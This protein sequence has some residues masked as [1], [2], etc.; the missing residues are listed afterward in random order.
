MT[1]IEKPSPPAPEASLGRDPLVKGS[2]AAAPQWHIV[3]AGAALAAALVWGAISAAGAQLG[4]L[5]VVGLL[6][7]VVLYRARFGFTSAWRQLV[8]VGQGRA[9]RA[10]MVMLAAGS[11]LFALVL[12]Q[13]WGLFGTTP[14]PY[15]FPLGVSL[16]V[17]SFLFGLGMQLAGSCASGTLYV[18]GSGQGVTIVTLI[19]FIAGS[20]LGSWSFPFWTK[21]T[22]AGP[23]VSLARSRLGY[24]GALLIQLAA[25]ALIAGITLYIQRRRTPPPIEESPTIPGWSRLYRG[26]WP[27]I[28]GALGLAAL[29]A[30]TL[31]LSGQPW[32][33]TFA[34]ALWG[35]KAL[36]GIGY[37]ISQWPY[38]H[39]GPNA[40]ALHHS[41]LANV[42]STMDLGIILGA[43]I[44]AGLAGSF[45]RWRLPR[46]KTAIA[47]VIGGLFMGYGARIAFGCN[48][49][50]YFSG[51]VSFSLHGWVWAAM[52][53]V[54][55]WVGIKFRPIFGLVN[56]KPTDS[57]C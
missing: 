20:V 30:V 5:G 16:V 36:Q 41:I 33:I 56:P 31:A 3:V 48:I 46:P 7:G 29:N 40:S 52:A 38:W 53:L 11:A 6:L 43:F 9:I 22:P 28:V 39:A 19:G 27:F 51:I 49:G 34:F 47:A 50:S 57:V 44:A 18:A 25:F 13:H 4:A 42:T 8:A 10:Q 2:A 17:G 14:Q 23:A 26:T 1:L 32:G 45:T 54:G 21:R 12:S 55:T 35:A 15:V 24:G 37:N